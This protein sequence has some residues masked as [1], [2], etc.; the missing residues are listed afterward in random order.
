MNKV[1]EPIR[2]APDALNAV[3]A[4]PPAAGS[5]Q[6]CDLAV[7]AATIPKRQGDTALV[8]ASISTDRGDVTLCPTPLADDPAGGA[9]RQVIL[10]SDSLCRPLAPIRCYKFPAAI[11]LGTCFSSDRSATSRFSRAFSRSSSLKRLS[12][13]ISRPPYSLDKR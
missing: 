10:P 11:S 3:L 5:Q 12:C 13:S 6:R 1:F 2:P 8:S 7:A 4:N 9:L